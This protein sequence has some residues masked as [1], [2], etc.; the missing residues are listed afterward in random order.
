MEHFPESTKVDWEPKFHW[1]VTNKILEKGRTNWIC[2]EN[3]KQTICFFPIKFLDLSL[4]S[5]YAHSFRAFLKC[6]CTPRITCLIRGMCS[7]VCGLSTL[8][9]PASLLQLNTTVCVC[10]CSAFFVWLHAC[11]L[12]CQGMFEC[13][14]VHG[15][16][17]LC[18]CVRNM[19]RLGHV[20]VTLFLSF[21]ELDGS[22]QLWLRR[23]RWTRHRSRKLRRR[24]G[25][26]N[27]ISQ[28]VL[29]AAVHL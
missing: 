9:S 19:K 28:Y 29:S 20:T 4:Q 16:Y 14:C 8:C 22:W 7:F 24:G 12:F 11:S 13:A 3:K 26:T 15:A 23:W 2:S 5:D 27:K 17:T 18:A 21:D 25:E 6:F 10:V 1:A